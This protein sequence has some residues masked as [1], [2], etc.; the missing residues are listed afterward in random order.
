MFFGDFYSLSKVIFLYVFFFL[1]ECLFSYEFVGAPS[2]F[3]FF[4]STVVSV[5]FIYVVNL[6]PYSV[7]PLLTSFLVTWVYL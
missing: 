5:L 2:F 7:V 3:F 4:A 1:S 6:S